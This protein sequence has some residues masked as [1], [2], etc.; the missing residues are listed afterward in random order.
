ML[1][2]N[3]QI[4]K[5]WSA[6]FM[7]AF[8]T[9]SLVAFTSCDDEDDDMATPQQKTIVE[10]AAETPRFSILV[11]A[12]QRTG[13]DATLNGTDEFTVFAPNNDAFG[14]L[15]DALN[16]AN[17]DELSAAVGGDDALANILLY[18][19]LAGEVKA[20]D[21]STG[22]VSTAG[23]FNGTDGASLSAYID[24]GAN[25]RINDEA[26]VITTDIDA[27]NGVIHE[28]NGVILPKNLV[29]L[30]S[31]SPAHTSLVAAV[32]A[33]DPAVA[34]RLSSETD[35][36]TVFAPTNTAFANLLDAAQVNDLA[37]LVAAI[38]VDGL[39]SVLLYHT[40]N[41]NVRSTGVPNGGVETLEG[42]NINTNPTALTVTD[43][44]GTVANIDVVDIQGTN[45]VIHVIDAVIQP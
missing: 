26:N 28:L 41:G 1:T 13:L 12:L 9:F 16:V 17:L 14:D 18:H 38:G 6:L 33:A 5:K 23:V 31:L 21:V 8:M 3:N 11:E 2:L 35:I 15:L 4:S 20:A 44:N 29:E 36:T 45:G 40:V 7:A 39:T 27:S 32:G 24:A 22:F 34:A 42:T 43:A 25:V 37:E 19:V 30:A 10:I